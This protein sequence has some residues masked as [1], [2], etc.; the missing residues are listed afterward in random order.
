MAR[1]P[2]SKQQDDDPPGGVG[3][4]RRV[5]DWVVANRASWIRGLLMLVFVFVLGLLKLVVSLAALFQ[6]LM[7]LITGAPNRQVQVFGRGLANFS[8]DL[9][10][11]LTCASERL[12]FPFS[13][14]T[15][16]ERDDV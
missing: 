7:L 9:T 14:W 2:P 6:F 5:L 11:Y 12:P 15:T 4:A 8:H 3:S 16:R 10:A 13:E 1:T